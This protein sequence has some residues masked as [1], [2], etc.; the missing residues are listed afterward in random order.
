VG[1]AEFALIFSQV[2][3]KC[4]KNSCAGALGEEVGST[5]AKVVSVKMTDFFLTFQAFRR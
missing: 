3:D 4:K 2:K 1:I 5:A